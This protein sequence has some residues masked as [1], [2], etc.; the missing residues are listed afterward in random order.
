MVTTA[1]ITNIIIISTADVID[2]REQITKFGAS[3]ANYESPISSTHH[4]DSSFQ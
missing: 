4:L 3:M 2:V 1:R